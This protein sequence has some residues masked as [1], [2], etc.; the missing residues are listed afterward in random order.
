VNQTEFVVADPAV[1]ITCTAPTAKLGTTAEIEVELQ[2]LTVAATVPNLMV[3]LP[4]VEPKFAPLMMIAW[5]TGLAE[6]D[7]EFKL[8]STVKASVLL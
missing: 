4:C 6:G 8:G 3:P 2:L 7:R 5:P 1:T